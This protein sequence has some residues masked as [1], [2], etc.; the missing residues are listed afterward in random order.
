MEHSD[1]AQQVLVEHGML[2]HIMEGLRATVAWPI[3]GGDFSRK[4]STLRFISQSFQRHLER[5]TSLEEFDGYMNL[6]MEA[7]PHLAKNVEGLREEHHRLRSSLRR[8]VHGLERIAATDQAAFAQ[9]IQELSAILDRVDEHHKKEASLV[10]EALER[11]G[12]GEG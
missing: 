11:D 3:H 12:G 10:Q 8:L 2:K 1:M 6:V 5:L 4:L 7:N 9:A